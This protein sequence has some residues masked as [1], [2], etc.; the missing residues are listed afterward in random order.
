MHAGRLREIFE[1]ATEQDPANR[2]AYLAE[3]CGDDAD[4]RDEVERL[5]S[6]HEATGGWLDV[7]PAPPGSPP[8]AIGQQVG[9]L[10][11]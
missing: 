2:A 9:Y 10:R 1:A 11:L 4:L 3:A 8:G 6:A 7:A 5:L